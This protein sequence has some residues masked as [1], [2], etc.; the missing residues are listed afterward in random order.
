[1]NIGIAAHI[2]AAASGIGARRYDPSLTSSERSSIENGIW[3]C[4]G[5]DGMVDRDAVRF[6]AET[7]KSIRRDHTEF[8]RLGTPIEVDAG[9]IAI[10]PSILAGGQVIKADETGFV[11]H[12]S[13]FLEGSSD[14]LVAFVHR[15]DAHPPI[16][17]YVL[18]SEL[19]LGGL[20]DRIPTVERDGTGWRMNFQW[21][22][23]APRMPAAD[24]SGMSR[25]TG[26]LISGSEYWAQ[27]FEMALEQPPGT[28]FANMEG[29]SH[30]SELHDTLRGS[31]WFEALVTC[32]IVRL[33]CIPAPD[34][35]GTRS[36]TCPQIPFVQRIC[37]VKVFDADLPKDRLAIEVEAD[38][39]GHGRWIGKLSLYIYDQESLRAERFKGQWMTENTRRIENGERALPSPTPPADWSPDDGFSD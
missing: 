20:L 24:F 4:R 13:F 23:D 29:G 37:G 38:L 12:L 9:L 14:D 39:T 34:S 3:L 25:H 27:C 19:G 2:T 32:E 5:C 10:G 15:F 1:M 31:T 30:I 28:W 7:L 35:L 6:T 11:V 16:S 8:V 26:A 36:N 21:Q 17:R 22:S 18:L 33:A